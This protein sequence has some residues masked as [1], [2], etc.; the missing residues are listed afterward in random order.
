MVALS[1]LPGV[2]SIMTFTLFAISVTPT[3]LPES[4]SFMPLFVGLSKPREKTSRPAVMAVVIESW[5]KLSPPTS[6]SAA[7][8]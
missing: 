1:V 2:S 6:P 3:A 5:V 4:T 7:R 8:F